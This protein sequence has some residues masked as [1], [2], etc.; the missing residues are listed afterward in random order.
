MDQQEFERCLVDISGTPAWIAEQAR[1]VPADNWE[2]VIH[3]GEGGWNRRQMLA[4]IVTI[5]KR[6]AMRVRIGAGIPDASGVTDQS[7]LPPINDWNQ[8]QVDLRAKAGIEDLLAEMRTNREDLIALLK[9]LTP[10]QRERV[11]I[12]RAGLPPI[13]FAEWMPH[14]HE[15]A[16]A[17]MHEVTG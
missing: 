17:H 11:H 13:S 4:H 5:D 10:E 7:K 8:E 2:T 9:S 1:S 12:D 3:N 14:I 15:H 16:V 6:H